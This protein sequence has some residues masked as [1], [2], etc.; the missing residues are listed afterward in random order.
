MGVLSQPAIAKLTRTKFKRYR[1]SV[2]IKS[3]FCKEGR[4]LQLVV[5]QTAAVLQP[6][7]AHFA[8]ELFLG[9]RACL[10]G[11]INGQAVTAGRGVVNAVAA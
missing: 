8:G 5:E 6:V 7:L 2:A 9:S 4:S 3:R 11:G 1:F 10:R